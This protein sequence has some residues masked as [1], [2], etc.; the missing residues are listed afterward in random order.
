MP[1]LLLELDWNDVNYVD[2]LIAIN[3][4]SIALKYSIYVSS[5]IF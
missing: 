1:Y 3:G 2:H 5:L 4:L